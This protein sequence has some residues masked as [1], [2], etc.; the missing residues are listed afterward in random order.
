[1]P[2]VEQQVAALEELIRS[3]RAA[4]VE[5]E[6]DIV[7]LEAEILALE[8]VPPPPLPEFVTH[9]G[10]NIPVPG[11][12]NVHVVLNGGATSNPDTWSTGKVPGPGDR[13]RIQEGALAVLDGTLECDV[14]VVD[15]S[16]VVAQ[17]LDT[18]LT[19]N[20]LFGLPSGRFGCGFDEVP[21]KNR[22]TC[23]FRPAPPDPMD[24]ARYW[25][26]LVWLGEFTVDGEKKA[27]Y[28]TLEDDVLEG[29]RLLT[30]GGEEPEGWKV[31]DT[32]I[33]HDC[34]QLSQKERPLGYLHIERRNI[35]DIP[36]GGELGM[37][38]FFQFDHKAARDDD[39]RKSVFPRVVNLTRNVRFVAEV[40]GTAHVMFTSHPKVDIR[41]ASFVG[42]G[43]TLNE[44]LNASNPIARYP[45]HFHHMHTPF[46]IEG[47]VIDGGD[48]AHN[49]KFGLVVHDTHYSTVKDCVFYNVMGSGIYQE[50]GNEW[51]CKFSGNTVIRCG[52]KGG[53]ADAKSGTGTQ[54]T[55][56]WI[57]GPGSEWTDNYAANCVS[58]GHT[59][60]YFYLGEISFPDGPGSHVMLKADGNALGIAKFEGATSFACMSGLTTWWTGTMGVK[61]RPDVKETILKNFTAA[62]CWEYGCFYYPGAR[63]TFDGYKIRGIGDGLGWYGGD[64]VAFDLVIRNADVQG[65]RTGFSLSVAGG[66][67]LLENC[68]ISAKAGININVPWT[69]G[70]NA[71]GLLPKKVTIKNCRFKGAVSIARICPATLGDRS[72]NLMV[73]DVVEVV[74]FQGKAGDSF[75]VFHTQQAPGFVPPASIPNTLYGG[76]KVVGSPEPGLTN[77]QLWAKYKVAVAGELAPCSTTRPGILG[78]VCP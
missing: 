48:E 39:G 62:N 76:L 41:F 67:Q 64:Y 36:G 56:Y 9:H 15:G 35:F 63:T 37:D 74:D 43:R 47:V 1:M 58:Y 70:F 3:T 49:R 38:D 28:A 18:K 46:H 77:A 45:L 22:F 71:E 57:S 7:R 68:Y 52:G 54:G 29:E 11:G 51:G 65:M 73:S 4:I 61:P 30:I 66:P 59:V 12:L 14:L 8:R 31:G 60:S 55:G 13:V 50:V 6:A 69:N 25:N 19:V 23:L 72:L 27:A 26:G 53:R 40:P 33:F 78:L 44:P 10:E 24:P 42:M 17:D 21:V 20:T 32:L 75:K 34:R 5:Y 16:F 2:T